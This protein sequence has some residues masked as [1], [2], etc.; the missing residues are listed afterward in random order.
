[1]RK[2]FKRFKIPIL[3]SG[4]RIKFTLYTTWGDQYYVGLSGIELINDEGQFIK[5]K[6]SQISAEPPDINILPGYG[7]D[8]RTVDKVVNGNYLNCDDFHQWLAPYS[9]GKVVTITI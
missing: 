7:D 5:I 3:P 8:P 9:K 2:Q 6:K 1:V 4:R